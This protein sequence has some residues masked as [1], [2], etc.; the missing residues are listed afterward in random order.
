MLEHVIKRLEEG[1]KGAQLKDATPEQQRDNIVS[2]VEYAL[3]VLRQK[4]EGM[5]RIT[6]R[7]RQEIETLEASR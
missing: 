1:L 7:L 6:A 3:V 2:R 4:N 5:A